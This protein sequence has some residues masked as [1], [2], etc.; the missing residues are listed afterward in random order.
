[1]SDRESAGGRSRALPVA[2]V[3]LATIAGLLAV[4]AIWAKRQALE[5][6]SWVETSGEL[7]ADVAIQE[8]VAGF[9]VDEL[10]ANADVRAEVAELLPPRAA[11]LAGPIA[12]GLRQAADEI[13]LRA[14][15]RPAVQDLWEEANRVAHQNLIAVVEGGGGEVSTEGGVV[16]LDLTAILSQVAAQIGLPESLVDKLPPDAANL[17]ILRADELEAAQ[18][19]V[20]VLETLA[21]LLLALTL[22]LYAIAIYISGERRRETLRAVGYSFV[23][24]GALALIGRGLAGDAVVGALTADSRNE[25]AV[26][27]VWSIGTSMLAEIGSAAILYGVAIIFSAWLAGPTRIA[28]SARG[29]AA[30]WLRRPTVAYGGLAVLLL[31]LFWWNP[32]PATERLAPSLLLIVLL[33]LATEMLRRRT[34]AEFP[35]RVTTFSAAGLAQTMAEQTREAIAR[36][37]RARAERVEAEAAGSRLDALERIARLRES[38]MLTDQE[39]EAEKRKLVPASPATAEEQ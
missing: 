5:T 7:I 31:L 21:W 23:V 22:L 38:G 16:T 9:L 32:T 37:T 13:A 28:T 2:L 6:E 4:F 11:P 34:V 12:G 33:T 29:F 36:R 25:P 18:T 19:G 10:Y 39:A 15:E 1:M 14:L 26:E 17:E 8:A 30:P 27:G 35:D 24:V 20:D 3:V